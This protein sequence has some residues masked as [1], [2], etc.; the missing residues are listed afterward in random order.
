MAFIKGTA[1]DPSLGALD[2]SGFTKAAEIQANALADLGDKVGKGMQQYSLNK[3]ELGQNTAKIEAFTQNQPDILAD[4]E[5]K[6]ADELPTGAFKAF[7]DFKKGNAT[8]PNSRILVSYIENRMEAQQS[9]LE[10]QERAAALADLEQ[11]ARDDEDRQAY[12]ALI[13]GNVASQLNEFK[14]KRSDFVPNMQDASDFANMR[15]YQSG[16]S[17]SVLNEMNS[18]MQQPEIQELAMRQARAETMGAETDAAVS[19][20]TAQNVVDLSQQEVEAGQQALTKGDLENKQLALDLKTAESIVAGGANMTDNVLFKEADKQAGE[21]YTK[22]A[23]NLTKTAQTIEQLD[24]I[25]VEIN[26]NRDM[27]FR[28]LG[29]FVPMGGYDDTFM[30]IY[31]SDL[32]DIQDRI[33]GIAYKTLRDTLGAQFTEREGQRLVDTYFNPNLDAS[34]NIKRL[35]MFRDRIKEMQESKKLFLD[36]IDANGTIRGFHKS[37]GDRKSALTIANEMFDLAERENESLGYKN[38]PTEF[39]SRLA[40]SIAEERMNNRKISFVPVEEITVGP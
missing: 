36:Y 30:A 10:E 34:T 3:Q 6:T 35:T 28:S 24:G 19:R 27:G 29:T 39:G 40:Q 5:T 38:E 11:R 4:F 23:T 16:V 1:V 37:L 25:L 32:A 17:L 9:Q 12:Q 15:S 18:L 21:I 26:E 8:L 7:Q 13:R 2:F 33:R 22:D 20:A 14:G 31:G